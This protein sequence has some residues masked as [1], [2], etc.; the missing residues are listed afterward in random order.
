MVAIAI[1]ILLSPPD[2]S[3]A[4]SS[5]ISTCLNELRPTDEIYKAISK[6][7]PAHPSLISLPSTHFSPQ[8]YMVTFI[9][10]T[11]LPL[12][13]TYLAQVTIGRDY[14]H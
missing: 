3:D 10:T 8:L 11:L 1:C 13:C 12:C 5:L 7:Y 4:Y 2:N 9:V 6:P 14:L